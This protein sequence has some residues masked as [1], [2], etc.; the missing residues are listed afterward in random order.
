[1]D[2]Q[3]SDTLT[4]VLDTLKRPQ[5]KIRSIADTSTQKFEDDEVQYNSD[6]TDDE[7]LAKEAFKQAFGKSQMWMITESPTRNLDKNLSN[8]VINIPVYN[9]RLRTSNLINPF[10]QE[11]PNDTKLKVEFQKFSKDA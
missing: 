9:F 7:T 6:T 5:K 3:T 8:K 1:V 11:I 10:G 2:F 4:T